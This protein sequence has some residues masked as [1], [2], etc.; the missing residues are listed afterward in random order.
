MVFFLVSDCGDRGGGEEGRGGRGR[1]GGG[2]K[3]AKIEKAKK[4]ISTLPQYL[5][6]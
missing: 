1:G 6:A 2:G 4:Q 5:Y 3:K